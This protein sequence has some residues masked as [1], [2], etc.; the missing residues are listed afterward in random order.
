MKLKIKSNIS[1]MK[2]ARFIHSKQFSNEVVDMII[3]P[4]IKDSKNAIKNGEIT[5]ALKPETLERR[6]ARKSPKSI[7][8]DKP[9]YDTGALYKSIKESDTNDAYSFGTEQSLGIEFL[10]YGLYHIK[11]DGVPERNFLKLSPK[12]ST[13]ISKKVI[14]DFKKALK[15]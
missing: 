7:G 5:P 6:K 2:L 9:L 12:T 15:K 8:G 13:K 1:F 11:G 3:D 14:K 10:K 4:F